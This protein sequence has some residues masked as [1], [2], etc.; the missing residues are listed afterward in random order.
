MNHAISEI[1]I[2]YWLLV[3]WDR[4]NVLPLGARMNVWSQSLQSSLV[5]YVKSYFKL[6]SGQKLAGFAYKFLNK[7][8]A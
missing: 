6:I 8:N 7:D 2:K 4:K 1:T 5:I 3:Q